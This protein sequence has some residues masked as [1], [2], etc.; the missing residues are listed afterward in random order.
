MARLCVDERGWAMARLYT[1]VAQA[2]EGQTTVQYV[3]EG[4]EQESLDAFWEGLD[5]E[6]LPEWKPSPWTCGTLC[7]STLA[8]VAGRGNVVA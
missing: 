2:E 6:Q 7:Q 1:I 5:A 4:R 3:G 8:I